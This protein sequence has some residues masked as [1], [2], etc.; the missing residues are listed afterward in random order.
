M[1]NHFYK[2]LSKALC[3]DKSK[4]WAKQ[5]VNTIGN[6][7][8]IKYI[9]PNGE[10]REVR[11]YFEIINNKVVA[12][13]IRNGEALINIISINRENVD[14]EQIIA[15]TPYYMQ[16]ADDL[17]ESVSN[18]LRGNQERFILVWEELQNLG[19]LYKDELLRDDLLIL[20]IL[21][22]K[23]YAVTYGF[24]L[25]WKLLH[26][27]TCTKIRYNLFLLWLKYI[28]RTRLDLSQPKSVVFFTMNKRKRIN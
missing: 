9:Q 25:L 18:K 12:K 4:R 19:I 15:L 20:L 7:Y 28:K 21:I 10:T 1:R 17:I 23:Q 14:Y 5:I 6:T 22:N 8:R 26:K 16:G 2:L 27:P 3:N 13:R 11:A 24:F